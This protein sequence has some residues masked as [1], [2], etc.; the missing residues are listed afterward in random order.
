MAAI[1]GILG[2]E[3][4]G[5]NSDSCAAML[6]ALEPFSSA[7]GN[8]RRLDGA[9]FGRNPDNLLPEDVFDRQPL[10]GNGG[11]LL[12]VADA[13]IDNRDELIDLLPGKM[14]GLASDADLLLA[15][16]TRWGTSIF[17]HVPGDYAMAA[18]VRGSREIILLRSP[19]AEKG[20]FYCSRN[21]VLAFASEPIALHELRLVD[22]AFEPE[23]LARIA[24][25]RGFGVTSV[26]RHIGLVGKGQILCLRQDGTRQIGAWSPQ[27]RRAGIRS[28]AEA[29][30]LLR[31]ELD[32]AVVARLRRR[33]GNVAVF[34]SSGRDSAAVATSAALAL[35]RTGDRLRAI[36]GAPREGFPCHH[37][38]HH[39]ADESELAGRISSKHSN[40]RHILARPGSIDVPSCFD[41]LHRL[42]H[43]PM[44]NPTQLPWWEAMESAAAGEGVRVLLSGGGGNFTIS[45]GGVEFFA[46]VLREIG[47]MRA[48]ALAALAVRRRPHHLRSVLNHGLGPVIP[49]GAYRS[50]ER[51]RAGGSPP[52]AFTT[53]RKPYRSLV[54][55]EAAA[56]WRDTRPRSSYRE[57]RAQLLMMSDSPGKLY[58]ARWGF[59]HRDPT[60]DA[61]LVEACHSLPAEYLF[62][63]RSE[64]PAYD[65]AFASRL[66]PEVLNA[67]K[68]GLQSADWREHFSKNVLRAA[69]GRYRQS[70]AVQELFDLDEIDG[71]VERGLAEDLAVLA[72]SLSVASFLWVHFPD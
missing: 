42:H 6:R 21:G 48:L 25:A 27:G 1:A 57:F 17:R 59:D 67:R 52:Q 37:L 63:G 61:R 54:E 70:R 62:S 3:R 71:R 69:F 15:A 22:K 18:H 68:R 64:R 45:L 11:S 72:S 39:V 24:V 36:T 20:L 66:P 43:M 40:I 7:E 44:L 5:L 50:L 55:A 12:F 2:T 35:D 47:S 46:D 23:K 4:N 33:E 56:E 32:R 19:F 30:E 28:P 10:A 14:R 53:L 49:A 31:A 29:G 13:R 26:F 38:A 16:W 51:A 9:C 65:H 41:E 8:L 34:L 58:N 60:L